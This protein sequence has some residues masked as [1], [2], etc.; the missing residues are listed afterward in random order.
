MMDRWDG[1]R[2]PDSGQSWVLRSATDRTP[3]H[4]GL[5]HEGA[6]GFLVQASE[7][8]SDLLR[9]APEL[10]SLDID[11]LSFPETGVMG[12]VVW[13]RQERDRA[14]FGVLCEDLAGVAQTCDSERQ[15]FRSVI[16][17]L[18]RWQ[19]FLSSGRA[20]ILS[21]E[22]MRGLMA[23]L[24][25]LRH[26]ADLGWAQGALLA[27]WD[28]P[29]GAPQDFR[30]EKLCL[31]VKSVSGGSGGTV[32]ISSEYQLQDL[33]RDVCLGVVRMSEGGEGDAALSL[34]EMVSVTAAG[35][36]ARYL[37]VFEQ[38][39]AAAGYLDLDLYGQPRFSL[40]PPEFFLVSE[41]FPGLH[42][43]NVPHGVSS[44][45]YELDMRVLEP[46]RI[47]ILPEPA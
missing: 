36:E 17:R 47:D 41:G 3:C 14:L 22:E 28:G 24:A 19:K 26:L 29:S 15:A 11:F 44:L 16:S 9:A 18:V 31:E 39:L 13:L 34:N 35:L 32:R 30:F 21:P 42:V 33:S 37:A 12:L 46:F 23:E 27:S 43:G 20:G 4:F 7:D 10:A 40:N 45:R 6:A 25:V 38:K 5:S 8:C 1:I 2:R